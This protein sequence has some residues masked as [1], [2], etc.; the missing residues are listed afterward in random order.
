MIMLNIL[1][2][3]FLNQSNMI[4]KGAP[5]NESAI[6][7]TPVLFA[8]RPDPAV[9]RY[10]SFCPVI[11]YPATSRASGKSNPASGMTARVPFCVQ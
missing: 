11:V 1:Y 6:V 5:G 2:T 10:F 7:I 4:Q 8:Y 9:M 3:K